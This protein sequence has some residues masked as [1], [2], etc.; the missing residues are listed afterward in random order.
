MN[1][2]TFS[3]VAKPKYDR[4]YDRV[5]DIDKA[6][7]YL[8][9]VCPVRHL[10]ELEKEIYNGLFY[11]KSYGFKRHYIVEWLERRRSYFYVP[12]RKDL[13]KGFA[14]MDIDDDDNLLDDYWCVMAHAVIH[15][16][17]KR[18]IDREVAAR[19]KHL[20]RAKLPTKTL[21]SNDWR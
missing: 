15:L 6:Q 12:N 5:Y 20:E 9:A 4:V 11:N 14:V 21:V 18:Q 1:T 17:A 3:N 13:V 19:R 7:A 16:L 10:E 2:L 8:L